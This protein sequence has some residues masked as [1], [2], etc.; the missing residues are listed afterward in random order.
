M[1]HT[2]FFSCHVFVECFLKMCSEL[3]NNIINEFRCSLIINDMYML[4]TDCRR[5]L[6]NKCKFVQVKR[7][8]D[9]KILS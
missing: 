4:C 7:I 5:T 2:I 6:K 8:K 1:A 3:K 9:K